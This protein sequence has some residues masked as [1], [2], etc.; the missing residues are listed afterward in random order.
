[1]V[2][3]EREDA[4]SIQP[5]PYNNRLLQCKQINRLKQPR[6][7]F[8]CGGR[9]V[10]AVVVGGNPNV[11]G[12]ITNT[13]VNRTVGSLLGFLFLFVK[14]TIIRFVSVLQDSIVANC[15]TANLF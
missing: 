5:R 10:G 1:M 4:R 6:F 3:I 13:V 2:I 11:D 8:L 15:L 12:F 14:A 7:G 9:G